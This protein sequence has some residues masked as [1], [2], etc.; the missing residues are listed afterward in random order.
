M[1]TATTT[2][3]TSLWPKTV[4]RLRRG[5]ANASSQPMRAWWQLLLTSKT[6]DG[7]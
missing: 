3:D 4:R 2:I 5:E 1:V 7:R 6:L